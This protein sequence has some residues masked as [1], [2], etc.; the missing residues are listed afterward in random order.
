M[1]HDELKMMIDRFGVSTPKGKAL[2]CQLVW[3]HGMQLSGSLR[4]E[5]YEEGD[6]GELFVMDAVIP[7]NQGP[8]ASTVLFDCDDLSMIMTVPAEAA[9]G[10][11]IVRPNG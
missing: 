2:T 7:T 9:D 10:P 3:K 6:D 8:K 1:R 4:V 11:R 5:R